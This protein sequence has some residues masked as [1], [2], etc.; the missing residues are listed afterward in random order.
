MPQAS[1]RP[2]KLHKHP[3]TAALEIIPV[4]HGS[5]ESISFNFL[6]TLKHHASMFSN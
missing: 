3:L 1:W 6:L 5:L 4:S 2:Q